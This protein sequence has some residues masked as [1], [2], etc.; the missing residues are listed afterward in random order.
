MKKVYLAFAAVLAVFTLILWG[1]NKE[2]TLEP[3]NTMKVADYD[4][5]G[6][7][8]NDF[9]SN[10]LNNLNVTVTD[11]N[12][13]DVLSAITS[14]NVDYAHK[15]YSKILPEDISSFNDF[16][17][18]L[19][20]TAFNKYILKKDTKGT[21]SNVEDYFLN[22]TGELEDMPSLSSMIDYLYSLGT[23]QDK[24][25]NLLSEIVSTLSE[26]VEGQI[27]DANFCGN[28]DR[29]VENFDNQGFN[30]G[31]IDGEMVASILAISTASIEWWQENPDAALAEDKM[32]AVVAADLGGAITGV[33]IDGIRQG[34]CLGAGFQDG[35]D[36]ASTGWAALGGA[37]DGSLGISS[38]IIKLITK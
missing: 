14:F 12:K 1:C 36:W 18:F 11:K 2:S 4:Y 31:D 30:N 26:S 23:L 38:K 33:V 24:S 20:N 34:I 5:L 7:M 9:M 6:K 22:E 17:K 10:A 8:H 13:D 28:I 19:D 3:S 21:G 32:P 15:S 25:Y 29:L 27:S 37:V 35:W 16:Q